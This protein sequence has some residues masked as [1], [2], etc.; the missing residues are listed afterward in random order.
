M[1]V[2]LGLSLALP[3]LLHPELIRPL[4][5]RGSIDYRVLLPGH[6][7]LSHGLVVAL[8]G[9]VVLLPLLLAGSRRLRWFA[10]CLALSLALAWIV[11]LQTFTSVWCFLAALLALQLPWVMQESR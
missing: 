7:W 6:R 5:A 1:G 3:L 9:G 4:V 11:S 8:Y 2:L 10:A